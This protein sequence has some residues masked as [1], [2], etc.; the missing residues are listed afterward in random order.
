MINF[1]FILLL[2]ICSLIA[3]IHAQEAKLEPSESTEVLIQQLKKE[4]IGT[5]LTIAENEKKVGNDMQNFNYSLVI[6]SKKHVEIGLVVDTRE[7]DKKGIHVV[8]VTPGSLAD[9]AGIAIGDIIIE[10]NEINVTDA[11]KLNVVKYLWNF[12]SGQEMT[13]GVMSG[14]K[15]KRV[16]LVTSGTQLPQVN[17]SIGLSNSLTE[18]DNNSQQCGIIYLGRVPKDGSSFPLQFKKINGVNKKT[19]G[20]NGTIRKIYTKLPVGNNKLEF[21]LGTFNSNA[22][23]KVNAIYPDRRA[24]SEMDIVIEANTQYHIAAVRVPTSV[25][26]KPLKTI[27]RTGTKIERR[28]DLEWRPVIWKTTQKYCD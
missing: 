23:Y 7:L 25:N 17:L 15:Y 16:T 4:I 24:V 13:L 27:K 18:E 19:S 2:V 26:D 1:I 11:Y 9:E 21:E 10:I 8:S 6:P 28:K 5:L 20:L 12:N 14:G 3:P 22:S